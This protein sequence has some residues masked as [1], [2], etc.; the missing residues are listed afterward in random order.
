MVSSGESALVSSSQQASVENPPNLLAT[1]AFPG[2]E[3]RKQALIIHHRD[4]SVVSS[5]LLEEGKDDRAAWA[6]R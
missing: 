3:N 5:E 1:Q 4:I 6:F 2:F